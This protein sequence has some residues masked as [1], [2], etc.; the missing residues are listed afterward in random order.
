M[1]SKQ[2]VPYATSSAILQWAVRCKNKHT[3]LMLCF[4]ENL[5]PRRAKT[6]GPVG[7]FS[8]ALC[9]W[10]LLWAPHTE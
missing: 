1:Q 4:S 6:G 8:E 5:R 7:P 2:P 9:V 3:Q 10:T